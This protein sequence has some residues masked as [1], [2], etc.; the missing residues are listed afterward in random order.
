VYGSI[1]FYLGHREEVDHYLE[2]QERGYEEKRAAARAAD[3]M[4]FQKLADARR[5]HAR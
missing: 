3:P 1:A 4:F 5:G 2:A